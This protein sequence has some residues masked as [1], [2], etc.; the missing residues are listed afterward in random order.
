MDK[1]NDEGLGVLLVLLDGSIK[2][3]PQ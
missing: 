2:S 3:T 1:P